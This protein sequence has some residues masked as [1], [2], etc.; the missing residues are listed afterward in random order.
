MLKHLTIVAASLVTVFPV[1]AG[2]ESIEVKGEGPNSVSAINAALVSAMEQVVGVNIT[3]QQQTIEHY[4]EDEKGFEF[5]ELNTNK[6]NFGTAGTATYRILSENCQSDKCVVRIRASVEYDD[7]A[8]RQKELKGMNKNR[9]TIAVELFEGAHS[10][11]FSRA[12]EARL[13]QDRKFR[14]ISDRKQP[15]VDYVLKGR[16]VEARTAKKVVD[17]SRTVELTGEHIDDVQVFYDSKVVV[18]Y[19]L[20]DLV[21]NQIKWSAKVPTT[22]ARNNLSFLLE[23]SSRKVFEQLK[24]NIYPMLLIAAEDGSLVLNSG[25]STVN[26]GESFE[27]FAAGEKI[28]DPITKESLGFTESKIG[29]I[30]VI[31]V[32]PKMAY[33]ELTE[34]N[35]DELYELPIVRKI[36]QNSTKVKAKQKT[37]E[38]PVEKK[39]SGFIL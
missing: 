1:F 2:I 29:V 14:V 33:V 9:R 20:I 17:N 28:I 36:P 25:G 5:N 21:N 4:K 35:R 12:I 37:I 34:G 19:Q 23:L 10:K 15:G 13:V 8:A 3:S 16:V 31:K 18:E 26:L 11:E 38:A 24:E 22:S 7:D 30:K 27:V 32:L 39:S 6:V